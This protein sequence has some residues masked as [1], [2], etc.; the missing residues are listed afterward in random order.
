MA[1]GTV[2]QEI[3]GV[4]FR[5]IDAYR[6][7]W[8]LT[9]IVAAV[10]REDRPRTFSIAGGMILGDQETRL[11]S[12]SAKISPREE[13]SVGDFTLRFNQ[14][15]IFY[16]SW[17][18]QALEQA[19]L[20]RLDSTGVGQLIEFRDVRFSEPF[21]R[22]VPEEA[23]V[24]TLSRLQDV[25][26]ASRTVPAA[27]R[28]DGQRGYFDLNVRWWMPDTSSFDGWISDTQ[29]Q[30]LKKAIAGQFLPDGEYGLP[31]ITLESDRTSGHQRAPTQG[32]S[33]R[34]LLRQ[35]QSVSVD[36]SLYYTEL[37]GATDRGVQ[38]AIRIPPI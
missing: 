29:Q 12:E 23:R 32:I 2:E 31:G 26:E 35:G 5:L 11:S 28:Y 17:Q 9:I 33:T 34:N 20:I 4:Y 8:G 37:I 24:A 15:V 19:S 14:P 36:L 30:D 3:E 27:W 16:V 1:G 10:N 21:G 18:G 22:P 25:L 7:S 13:T 38:I 6:T